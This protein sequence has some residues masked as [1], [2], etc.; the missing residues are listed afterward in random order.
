MVMPAMT[1]IKPTVTDEAVEAAARAEWRVDFAL[2]PWVSGPED[3]RDYYR[4]TARAAL[5]AAAPLIAAQALRD[6]ADGYQ[7]GGWADDLPA[8]G[9]RPAL[10]LGMSQRAVAWLRARADQIEAKP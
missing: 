8:G 5:E 9:S 7:T 4:D 3:V 1:T 2:T 10:I 6:A